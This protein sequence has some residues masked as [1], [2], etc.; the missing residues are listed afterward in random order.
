MGQ[1]LLTAIEVAQQLG[2]TRP[3]VWKLARE[4]KIEVIIFAG[5]RHFTQSAVDKFLLAHTLPANDK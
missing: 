3:Y 1:E 5:A 4:R 2:V